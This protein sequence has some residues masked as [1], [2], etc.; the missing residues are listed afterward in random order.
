MGA[1]DIQMSSA[2]ATTVARTPGYVAD[3][4]YIPVSVGHPAFRGKKLRQLVTFVAAHARRSIFVIG[5]DLLRLNVMM[6]TGASESEA[7]GVARL[8]GEQQAMSLQRERRRF[9]DADLALSFVRDWTSRSSF[10]PYRLALERMSQTNSSFAKAI[11]QCAYA[12]LVSHQDRP[13]AV[14]ENSAMMLSREFLLEEIAVFTILSHEGW[15]T[16]AYPG[17]ELPV[18]IEL[19]AGRYP[20]APIPLQQR[21]SIQLAFSGSGINICGSVNPKLSR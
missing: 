15:S 5:D 18:L 12:Y 14:S 2:F 9:P 11:E 6:R 3:Q 17:P 8:R 13:L 21:I 19:A 16:E 4:W 7:L 1:I 20:E 10:L